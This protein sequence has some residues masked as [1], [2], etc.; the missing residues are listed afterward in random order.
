MKMCHHVTR[1]SH[2]FNGEGKSPTSVSKSTSFHSLV[3]A[4]PQA[5]TAIMTQTS[6]LTSSLPLVDQHYYPIVKKRETEAPSKAATCPQLLRA[7][8]TARRLHEVLMCGQHLFACSSLRKS[9][10]VAGRMLF[11]VSIYMRPEEEQGDQSLTLS[12]V[13]DPCQSPASPGTVSRSKFAP[14]CLGGHFP[15]AG[16]GRGG[17]FPAPPA[18]PASLH[19]TT[20]LNS[21]C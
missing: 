2:Q 7:S 11:W 19:G 21:S 13:K 10:S 20:D 17:L 9:S 3:A 16:R 8:E 4:A 5:G 18:R 1:D 12:R 6:F 15:Q 14:H